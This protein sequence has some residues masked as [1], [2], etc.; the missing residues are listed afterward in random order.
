MT[1]LIQEKAFEN[2]CKNVFKFCGLL[3]MIVYLLKVKPH[4]KIM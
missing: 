1:E 3:Y 2:V 4:F